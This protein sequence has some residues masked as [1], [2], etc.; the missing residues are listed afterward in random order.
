MEQKRMTRRLLFFSWVGL[1]GQITIMLYGFYRI[2]SFYDI[3]Y[4]PVGLRYIIQLTAALLPI[5]FW[6]GYGLTVSKDKL[7]VKIGA[8]IC[9]VFSCAKLVYEIIS[10]WVFSFAPKLSSGPLFWS[11]FLTFSIEEW[12]ILLL[13]LAGVLFIISFATKG[14]SLIKASA[15]LYLFDLLFIILITVLFEQ[16]SG[17]MRATYYGLRNCF[18][19][20]G[21]PFFIVLIAY[22]SKYA[23][24][25]NQQ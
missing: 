11:R 10:I 5:V 15:I 3:F 6:F 7:G 25:S 17:N 16:S 1:L 18:H 22:Q 2:V 4:L 8:I 20:L 19:V 21:V 24:L 9:G 13:S 12:L 14:K 23:R